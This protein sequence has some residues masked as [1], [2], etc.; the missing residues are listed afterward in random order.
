[1]MKAIAVF[2]TLLFSADQS[3]VQEQLKAD[4]LGSATVTVLGADAAERV[5]KAA[6]H[7]KNLIRQF[8]LA[9]DSGS[10]VTSPPTLSGSTDRPVYKIS[11]RKCVLFICQTVKLNIEF[12]MQKVPGTCDQNWILNGDLNRST[13]TISRSYSDIQI[14]VCLRHHSE[15]S[16]PGV[17]LELEGGAIRTPDFNRSLIQ[18][19]VL[20]ML[21]LQLPSVVQVVEASLETHPANQ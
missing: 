13:D 3:F 21:K 18:S 2:C 20:K 17:T 19:Q 15:S 1:M 14:K 12:S 7:T 9:L 11:V 5:E 10:K 16:A 6:H 4:D 8:R